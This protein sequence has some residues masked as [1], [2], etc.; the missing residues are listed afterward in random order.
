MHLYPTFLPMRVL[1][2]YIFIFTNRNSSIREHWA[3]WSH[4]P[5]PQA[6]PSAFNLSDRQSLLSPAS[7]WLNSVSRIKERKDMCMSRLLYMGKIL[8]RICD[9]SNLFS[10]TGG[11]NDKINY[12]ILPVKRDRLKLK[13]KTLQSIERK[14]ALLFTG[15]LKYC[16][17]FLK[18]WNFLHR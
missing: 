18:T 6:F 14:I 4:W 8:M 11:N 15:P 9:N 5:L 2:T 16:K 1:G 3:F 12:F 17:H 7:I 13:L 10:R